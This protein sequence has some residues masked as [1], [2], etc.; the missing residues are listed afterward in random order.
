MQ[1]LP[2]FFAVIVAIVAFGSFWFLLFQKAGYESETS[3]WMAIG[4]FIPLLNVG[5]AIYFVSTTW[6]VEKLVR[7]SRGLA[8]VGTEDDAFAALSVATRLESRGEVGAAISKY[9]K[10]I[11][12]FGGTEAAKDAEASIRDLKSK[13]GEI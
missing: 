6:P 5:I 9:E 11:R 3:L 8:E 12:E 10:V 1:D 13:R 2:K 4:M 7:A